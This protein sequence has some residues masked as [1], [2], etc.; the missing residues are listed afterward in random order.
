MVNDELID[1]ETVKTGTVATWLGMFSHKVLP[2]IMTTGLS[3]VS[4]YGEAHLTRWNAYMHTIGMPFTIYGMVQ[5]IPA[6]LQATP[7]NARLIAQFLYFLYGGHYLLLD[8]RIAILYYISYYPSLHYGIKHY[9]I[10]Y[11]RN[12]KKV[13]MEKERNKRLQITHNTPMTISRYLNK[14]ET[15]MILAT[16]LCIS[17]LALLF[18]EYAGHYWG[19]D[20]PSRFEAIP[21]AILYAKYFSLHHIFF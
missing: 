4:Y 6:L 11:R 1:Y 3:G 14:N 20:I 15:N 18:Q 21:N 19:G 10:Q 9:E 2:N 13:Q 5:W 8:K 12:K 7:K 16:G 17:T